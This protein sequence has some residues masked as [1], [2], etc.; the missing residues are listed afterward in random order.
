MSKCC[1]VLFFE[2]RTIKVPTVAMETTQLV[3]SQFKN[4]QLHVFRIK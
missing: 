2:T 4:F 3:L 1:R